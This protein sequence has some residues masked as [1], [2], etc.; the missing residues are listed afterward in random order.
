MQCSYLS[1]QW[2]VKFCNWPLTF[3]EY[4]FWN[5][6]T[7]NQQIWVP[8]IISIIYSKLLSYYRVKHLFVLIW[9]SG[10]LSGLDGELHYTEKHNWNICSIQTSPVVQLF[11]MYSQGKISKQPASIY[12]HWHGFILASNVNTISLVIT[13][14]SLVIGDTHSYLRINVMYLLLKWFL[15]G[16]LF[17]NGIELPL[18]RK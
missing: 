18:G 6:K 13:N 1:S 8:N 16:H 14:D 9:R 5:I 11:P 3:T 4:G 7:H 17:S 10:Q 15:F 2:T 12:P